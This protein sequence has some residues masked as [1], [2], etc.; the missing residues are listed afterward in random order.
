MRFAVLLLLGR[1]FAAEPSGDVPVR[2]VVHDADDH[3][4]PTAVVRHAREMQ[5][6][7]VNSADGSW[8]ESV[9]YLPD[10]TEIHFTPGLRLELEIS[11]PGFVTQVLTYD[12]KRRH[13]VVDVTLPPLPTDETPLEEPTIGFGRDNP[14]EPGATP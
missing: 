6:H 5:R 8:Q 2:V 13:N 11:A 3:P 9:L 12:V 1:A 7:R 14:L 10:G 4:I